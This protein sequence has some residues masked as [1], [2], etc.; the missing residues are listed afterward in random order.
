MVALTV[1]L[2][3]PGVD[4]FT[5]RPSTAAVDIG[6][7]GLVHTPTAGGHPDLPAGGHDE[8]TAAIAD[9]DRSS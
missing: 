1:R 8:D 7:L 5:L 9:C 6:S 2:T 4:N 3:P